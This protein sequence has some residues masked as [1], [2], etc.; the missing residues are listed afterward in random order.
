MP[1]LVAR[2]PKLFVALCSSVLQNY[3]DNP[4]KLFSDM[5]VATFLDILTKSFFPCM[6]KFISLFIS[7]LPLFIRVW[8]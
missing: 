1:K 5:Y 7:Y 3:F 4:T 2:M 6:Q 8:K